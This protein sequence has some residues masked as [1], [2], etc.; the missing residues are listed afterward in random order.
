GSL[1]LLQLHRL[2]L[3]HFVFFQAEDGIRDRNVTGVQTCALPI[4]KKSFPY[5]LL[6]SP[7]PPPDVSTWCWGRE[8]PRRV[9]LERLPHEI[10]EQIGRASCREREESREASGTGEVKRSRVEAES[11]MGCALSRTK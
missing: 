2:L 5:R 8:H 11:D 6:N 9:H 4:S 10:A 7:T 1:V 3:L